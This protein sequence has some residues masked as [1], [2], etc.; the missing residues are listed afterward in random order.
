MKYRTMNDVKR[1]HTGYFF[2]SSWVWKT[3]LGSYAY[4]DAH[5]GAY[6]ITSERLD[7]HHA[8]RY[9]VRYIDVDGDIRNVSEF[10]EYPTAKRA[11]TAAQKLADR[12][13]PVE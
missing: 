6:F 2:A 3:R 10:L 13:A 1:H 4:P 7:D 11:R 12:S 9:T 8:R 5:D